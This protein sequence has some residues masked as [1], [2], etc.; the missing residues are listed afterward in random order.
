MTANLLCSPHRRTGLRQRPYCISYFTRRKERLLPVSSPTLPLYRF[1]TIWISDVHLGA[2]GC[3][4]DRLLD[5]LKCT[6][7]DYLYLVGD[8]V[9]G[10]KLKR[11]WYWPQLHNDVVQK[12]L[13]R[14]RKGTQIIYTPGNHDE[15]A[16]D[17][18]DFHFG[19]IHVVN[20]AIHTTADGKRLLVLH[21]DAF[22]VVVRYAKWLAL[23][24]DHAYALAMAL[25]HWLNAA[26]NLLGYPHWS[27]SAYLKNKVKNAVKFI[28]DF[29]D[30][31]AHVAAERQVDGIVCGHIH[32]PALR[33]VKGVLYCN[34]GDWME[35]CSALV[36]HHDGRLQILYWLT[37]EQAMA[38]F[39]SRPTLQLAA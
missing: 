2:K 26:R 37:E 25:N 35:T 33:Q 32:H 36:E 8:M 27:L 19:G 28:G 24:G 7:S 10:W 21:G 9:D 15:F 12:L 14:S 30:A 11:G 39:M 31:L 38:N 18:L 23:L 1:R 34:D 17:Y 16:R 22:D 5:F 4:A 13:R 20:E 3:R 6:E 29:E